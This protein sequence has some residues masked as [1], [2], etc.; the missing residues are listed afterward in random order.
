MPAVKSVVLV[1][2]AWADGSSWSKIVPT[3][4]AAG[5]TVSCVQLPLSDVDSDVAAATRIINAQ[6]GPVFL[7][8]HSYG[9]Y[10]ITEAGVN[11]KVVGLGYVAAFAPD[12][13]Q[14]LT[15]LVSGYPATPTFAEGIKPIDDGYLLL[16]ADG[17]AKYFAQDVTEEE[18]AVMAATQGA[19]SSSVLGRACKVAAWHEK[20][21]WYIVAKEDTAIHPDEERFHAKN[22]GA[23]KT[24]IVDASHVPM[25]SK[26]K[27]VAEFMLEA[28]KELSQ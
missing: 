4:Q 22:I 11:P 8:G 19:T 25:I 14:T 9:G 17:L 13:G 15:D 28:I 6:D 2:G 1:H 21:S 23:K 5:L 3:L 16:T 24:I 12:K 27:E 7:A 18:K 26:P 10:V 20:P